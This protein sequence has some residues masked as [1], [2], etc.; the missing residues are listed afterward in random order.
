MNCH[1]VPAMFHAVYADNGDPVLLYGFDE[2]RYLFL[3]PTPKTCKHPIAFGRWC[4]NHVHEFRGARFI[5]NHPLSEPVL[6][7]ARW[8][9]VDLEAGIA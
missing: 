9:G 6:R 1:A 4:K 3:W 5:Y 2:N 8:L 7:W